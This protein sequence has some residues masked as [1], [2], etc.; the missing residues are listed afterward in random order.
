M[1]PGV[2]SQPE[3]VLEQPGLHRETDLKKSKTRDQMP[4]VA[5]QVRTHSTRGLFPVL[6]PLSFHRMCW[7]LL[8]SMPHCHTFI[9]SFTLGA[10]GHFQRTPRK[11]SYPLCNTWRKGENRVLQVNIE[12]LGLCSSFC[13]H[14]FEEWGCS[15]TPVLFPSIC[16]CMISS[17]KVWSCDEQQVVLL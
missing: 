10:L 17:I 5:L 1:D 7:N 12:T 2:Q 4:G 15:A 13:P 14:V 9:G 6:F 11:N 8:L 16:L 3:Q